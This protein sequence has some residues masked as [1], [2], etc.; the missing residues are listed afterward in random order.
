MFNVKL[1]VPRVIYI[2]SKV[3]CNEQ[4]FKKCNKLLPRNRKVYN[5]YEWEK[6][7][8]V[9]IEKYHNISYKHLLTHTVEGVYETKMPLLFRTI[10]ELGFL[11]KPI[12]SII[13][14]K[15]QALGRTYK[16]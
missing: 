2:N 6:S 11:V 8:E 14:R 15:E 10:L 9:F 13:D 12:V 5:L 4:E 7:E 1:K 16:I 3:P